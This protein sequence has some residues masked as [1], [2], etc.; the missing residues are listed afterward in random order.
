MIF[1]TNLVNKGESVGG[2]LV[3]NYLWLFFLE[4]IKEK[5]FARWPIGWV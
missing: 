4:E 5:E 2:G 3:K 1:A